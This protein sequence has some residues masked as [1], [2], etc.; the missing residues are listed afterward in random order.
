[1]KDTNDD[2]FYDENLKQKGAEMT[3]HEK[4]REIPN[5]P[6]SFFLSLFIA[7]AIPISSF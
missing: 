4:I 3:K 5:I 6:P 1:M 7:V 2:D